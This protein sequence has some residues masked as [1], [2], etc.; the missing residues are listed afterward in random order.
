MLDETLPNDEGEFEFDMFVA[1]GTPPLPPDG[2]IDEGDNVPLLLQRQY[3]IPH[4]LRDSC[5]RYNET[6]SIDAELRVKQKLDMFDML[7]KKLIHIDTYECS[8]CETCF[9]SQAHFHQH[10]SEVHPL[11][12]FMFVCPFC[13]KGESR[14]N[15][16][17]HLANHIHSSG[18]N[19][20]II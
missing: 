8:Y 4:R 9:Q 12:F 6:I 16:I 5:T 20:L 14:Y 18:L 3:I 17:R 19:F 15:A 11:A 10:M 13:G 7:L 2:I 1:P